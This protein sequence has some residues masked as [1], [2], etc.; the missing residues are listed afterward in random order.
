MS[1]LKEK[2]ETQVSYYN[3]EANRYKSKGIG[4][5]FA[6]ICTVLFFYN[7]PILYS[8]FYI[9]IYPWQAKIGTGNFS[10]LILFLSHKFLFIFAN[11]IYFV[12]YKLNWNFFERYK[13]NDRPWPWNDKNP[14][15]WK[16]TLKESIL[17]IGINHFIV[18][19]STM[20]VHYFRDIS[21]YPNEIDNLPSHFDVL[22]QIPFFM[23]CEDFTFYWVHRFFHEDFIYPYLHKVHHKYIN[24]ISIAAEYSHPIDY[25]FS[26]IFATNSGPLILG[27]K[28]HIV[29]YLIWLTLRIF[30]TTDGHSG[31]EFSWSPFRLM[32]FSASSEYHNYHHLKFKGNY[33]SFFT[34]LD[35]L[36]GTVNTAYSKLCISREKFDLKEAND[37]KVD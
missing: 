33:S 12:I 20:M 3:Y 29:T 7:V 1:D 2:D 14:E 8:Q 36:F 26:S 34:Y 24:S 10:F 18:L 28:T 23:I 9:S 22:W 6:I 31:Y 35:R 17:L 30:E 27:S 21:P 37:K 16:K 25:L 19:P 15:I 5:I 13:V 4:L 32:P 11:S